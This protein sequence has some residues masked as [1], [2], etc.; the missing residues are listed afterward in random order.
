MPPGKTSLV[1]CWAVAVVA[2]L[3]AVGVPGCSSG[4]THHAVPPF[5]TTSVSTTTSSVA[6]TTSL[7]EATETSGEP[8]LPPPPAPE[9][10]ALPA[11]AALAP[12][13]T[14]VPTTEPVVFI[15]IDDGWV[16]DRAVVDLVQARHV[17]VSAFLISGAATEDPAYF[18]ELT[19]PQG[20]I[21]DHSRTHPRMSAL[22]LPR[23][24]EQI[25]GAADTEQ[26]LFGKRPMLFR[27][28]YGAMNTST[29]AA[30]EACGMRAV[31]LWSAAMDRGS[32]SFRDKKGLR[33]GDIVLLHF[34]RTLRAD[35]ER[36]LGI[37]ASR[38][39]SIGLLESYI[40]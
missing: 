32:L 2:V 17:P 34:R 29:R 3:L 20:G 22:S 12:V 13:V 9:S 8:A 24:R 23:Q 15:T 30:A 5:A 11:T 19:Q 37:I 10:V 25:C 31:V 33:A 36:L 35:L 26:R 38:H 27:P 1:R 18:A 21:E 14:R 40:G 7:V 4:S 39:L 16:R 6:T 28:P